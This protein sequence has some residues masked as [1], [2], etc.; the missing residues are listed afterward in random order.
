MAIGATLLLELTLICIRSLSRS[1]PTNY[2]LL[3]LHSV[4]QAYSIS[5]ICQQYTLQSVF[6]VLVATS[7]A[8][9]AMSLYAAFTKYDITIYYSIVSGALMCTFT[10]VVL[11]VLTSLPL[12]I[13]I[14]NF[15]GVLVALIFVAIDTQIILKDSKWGIGS[16][17][18]IV[19][20]LM[21]KVDFIAIFLHLLSILGSR[22]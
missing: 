10:L 3:A 15:I 16:D 2:F 11:V 9:I 17:D 8:F 20:A 22:K 21:L 18:Y 1:V 14:Y 13:V 4:T 12:L 5:M 7:A 6:L 19:A